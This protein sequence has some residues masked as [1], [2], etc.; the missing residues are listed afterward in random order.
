MYNENNQLIFVN[1]I[2][3]QNESSSN[4]GIECAVNLEKA[5]RN[6][7]SSVFAVSD[8]GTQDSRNQPT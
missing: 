6:N 3:C 1:T 5:S 4:K 7:I 2:N 8:H